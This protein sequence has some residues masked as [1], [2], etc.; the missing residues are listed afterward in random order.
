MGNEMG[1]QKL[2][3]TANEPQERYRLISY[4]G[5][6]IPSDLRNLIIA[7]FLNSLRY[8]NDLFKLIDKDAF[9]FSYGKFIDVLLQRP[10][11]SVK[12]A[13]LDDETVLGWC[14][15]EQKILHYIWVKK[16]VRRQGIGKAL[17]PKDFDT[18]SHITNKGINI[19]VN[20]YPEKR[21][22]PFA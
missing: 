14:M 12:F 10:N 19:W 21:F 22:N 1:N 11:A 7:P 8:G 4:K 18:I 5:S 6:V 2:E 3:S 20:Y 17:M 16:E 13:I 15:S 9:Y